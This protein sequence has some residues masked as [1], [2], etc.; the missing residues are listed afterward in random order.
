[1]R[2]RAGIVLL[3]LALPGIAGAQSK[4]FTAQTG[5]LVF[6]LVKPGAPPAGVDAGAYNQAIELLKREQ[7][8]ASQRPRLPATGQLA[9][10][11]PALGIGSQAYAAPQESGAGGGGE[12][13]PAGMG[14]GQAGGGYAAQNRP[15]NATADK[16]MRELICPCGCARQDIHSCDCKTAA[17]LRGKVLG[18]LAGFDLNTPDGKKQ[19]YDKVL[20]VF[21]SE[22]SESVLATPRTLARH[23]RRDELTGYGHTPELLYRQPLRMTGRAARDLHPAADLGACARARWCRSRGR[24]ASRRLRGSGGIGVGTMSA[25]PCSLGEVRGS[26]RLRR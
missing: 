21:V 23:D 9:K 4:D 7:M 1:M 5:A 15:P 26:A 16:A 20:E 24:G 2:A 13:I 19:G 8:L 14:M 11:G 22:Y 3:F 6:D 10:L 12:H 17:D 18:I 25:P